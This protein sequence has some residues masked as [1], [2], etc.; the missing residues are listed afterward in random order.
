MP[1]PAVAALATDP[2]ARVLVFID[3]QN[4]YQP[5]DLVPTT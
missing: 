1:D 4:L 2:A 3:G 5:V